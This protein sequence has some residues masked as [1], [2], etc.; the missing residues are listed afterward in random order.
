M[1][2]SE[3]LISSF[4]SYQICLSAEYSIISVNGTVIDLVVQAKSQKSFFILLFS[5]FP[6]QSIAKSY[7]VSVTPS[8]TGVCTGI[9]CPFQLY[10]S[11][12]FLPPF[13]YSTQSGQNDLYEVEIRLCT[14][15][16]VFYCL[17]FVLQNKPQTSSQRR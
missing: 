6:H 1:V 16:K 13:T 3:R 4:F 2:K 5:L 17:P 12:V 9:F 8:T 15:L 10:P 11:L 14:L 7:Q